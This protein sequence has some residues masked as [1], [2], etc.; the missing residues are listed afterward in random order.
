ME[1]KMR[2]RQATA[3]DLLGICALGEEVNAIHHRAFPDV[4]AGP[5]AHDRDAA[6]WLSSLEK[7]SATT[8]V[9][10]EDGN[11]LGFVNVSIVDE[12]HSL[13]QP[14]RF[15]RVGSVCVTKDRRGK[16]SALRSCGSPRTGSLN[17]AAWKS[18]SMCGRSTLT[19]C[20]CMKS[21]AM[22]CVLSSWP[23]DCQAAR[24]MG[25]RVH[26]PATSNK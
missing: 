13:L 23:N 11:L 9:A 25:H 8:F 7:E 16:A 17:M 10:E 26:A 22:R 6:Y 21:S 3:A 5:G 19:H 24:K 18:A 14:M 4:F 20:T 12:S 15:G 2:Y 1:K